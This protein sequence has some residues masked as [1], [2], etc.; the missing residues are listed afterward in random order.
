M[1][2]TKMKCINKILDSVNIRHNFRSFPFCVAYIAELRQRIH[3][4][5]TEK[6]LTSH[7]LMNEFPKDWVENMKACMRYWEIGYESLHR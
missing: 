3:E 6:I 7:E 5:I 4:W 1:T 2:F